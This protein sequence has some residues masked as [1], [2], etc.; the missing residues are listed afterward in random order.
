MNIDFSAEKARLQARLDQME[1]LEKVQLALKTLDAKQDAE[2][3][4]LDQKHCEEQDAF[5]KEN[6]YKNFKALMAELGPQPAPVTKKALKTAPVSPKKQRKARAKLNPQLNQEIA[7]A[8]HE[9]GD[10]TAGQI[11]MKFGVSPYTVYKV[12]KRLKPP[13]YTVGEI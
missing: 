8:Y 6:G 1:R 7:R 12:A 13:G 11:A 9:R 2:E 3:A 4:Q 10:K 5:A